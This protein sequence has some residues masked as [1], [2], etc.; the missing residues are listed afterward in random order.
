MTHAD[1]AV[2]PETILVPTGVVEVVT[3]LSR[4]VLRTL[5]MRDEFPRPVKVCRVLRHDIRAVRKWCEDRIAAAQN[6]EGTAR[7]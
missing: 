5:W 6:T 7:G 1:V 4:D 2:M 3:G